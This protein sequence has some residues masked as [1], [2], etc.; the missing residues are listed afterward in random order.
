MKQVHIGKDV[1]NV[2]VGYTYAEMRLVG[3]NTKY[4]V[5]K[6]EI[7]RLLDLPKYYDKEFSC[8]CCNG[9]DLRL[10]PKDLTYY[11]QRIHYGDDI[12]EILKQRK[13]MPIKKL[14]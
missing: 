9:P 2:K 14:V 12:E 10:G 4:V 1:W 3:S 6:F 11:L 8:D 5:N 13:K 7:A